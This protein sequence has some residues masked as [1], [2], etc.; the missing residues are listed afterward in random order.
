M[1]EDVQRFPEGGVETHRRLVVFSMFLV[2]VTMSCLVSF[3]LFRAESVFWHYIHPLWMAVSTWLHVLPRRRHVSV[4][5][6]LTRMFCRSMFFSLLFCI[7][8]FS[9]SAFFFIFII[10]TTSKR[11]VLYWFLSTHHPIFPRYFV[12]NLFI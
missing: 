6:Q 2:R 9:A 3:S 10:F 1:S 5:L 11:C 12:C 4:V 7:K 8:V